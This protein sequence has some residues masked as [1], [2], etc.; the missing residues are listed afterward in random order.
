MRLMAKFVFVT[1]GVVSGLGKGITAASLARLL[2]NRGYKVFMQKFDPYI[3]ID[4]GTMNP[5]QHGEVF[6]TADGSETDLDLGHYERFIDEELNY[7]SNITTGRIYSSVIAKER[8]GDYLGGTVQVIPHIT[9][10]IK[11]KVFEAAKTSKAD[12][13]ITEIG[14]TIGDI[15]SLPYL[16]SLRQIRFELGKTNVAFLH[17]TLLP[18]IFGSWELKTKPTQH[19]VMTLRSYGI[20]PD[21]LVCRTPQ[22]ISLEHKK[23]I[24]MFCDVYLDN[25]IEAI[26]SNNIYNIPL[27]FYH[28]RLDKGVLE[29]LDLPIKKINNQ[30]WQK[31]V[32][33]VDNLTGEV[34]IALVGKYTV[35]PDAYLSVIEAL[36]HAGYFYNT[37]VN[38]VLI[39]A[40]ELEQKRKL[41]KVFEGI[42]GIVVP[43]GFG[44]RGIEGKIKAITYAR[45]NNIPFLGLCLGMQ[46]ASIEIAR[47][48]CGLKNANSIEWDNNTNCPIIDLMPEQKQINNYGG[49]LRLGNYDCALHKKSKSYAL[50]KK[51]KIQERHRHRYEFNNKYRQIFEENGV[52]FAGINPERDLLEIIELPNHKFFVACQFHPEFKSRP[53]N[54]HPL[55][56]GFVNKTVK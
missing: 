14:G 8:Q 33:T 52:L 5:V 17:V 23:K 13:V 10:E 6:V 12:I 30:E 22:T 46:L 1:G 18:Y 53:T 15:E 31:L 49:T 41:S 26:D 43:G 47:N 40:E 32:N 34:N 38:V 9:N 25:V 20:Q 56:L 27:H 48:I 2:K 3:N 28:Q 19:S 24:A 7:T 35:L 21:F 16:E 54:P 51:S 11:A 37:K 45:T 55:F 44:G 42:S 29:Q 36:K 50:Y 4:P 39:D